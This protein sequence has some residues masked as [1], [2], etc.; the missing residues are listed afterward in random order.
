M[1]VRYVR[2]SDGIVANQGLIAIERGPIVYAVEQEDNEIELSELRISPDARVR[3]VW[4]PE[5]LNG[6]TSIYGTE[7]LGGK[8]PFKAIPY[9]AW[10]NRESGAMRVWI[11]RG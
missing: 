4:E 6:V 11:G 7:S 3:A 1:P 10:A 9:Y 8:R 2:S 5:F